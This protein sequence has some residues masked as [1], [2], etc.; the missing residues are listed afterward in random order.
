MKDVRIIIAG[1]RDFSNY[2]LLKQNVDAI[3][4][5]YHNDSFTIISGTARGAD[6]LGEKYA[7]ENHL[8]L[9]RFP[10]NWDTYGKAAGHIRNAQ[11]A[12]YASEG[13]KGILV[14]FWDAKSRGTYDM[15]Q[16]ARKKG[17]EVYIVNY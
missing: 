16:T 13:T 7:N 5:N 2:S 10:A 17:L 3:V 6:R 4:K 12:A 9:R 1:G 15:I 8:I 14:A 11:M